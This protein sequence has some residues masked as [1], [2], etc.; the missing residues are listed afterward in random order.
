MSLAGVH[1]V[2]ELAQPLD[3]A[4]HAAGGDL[5]PLGQFLGG[6]YPTRLQQ[7]EQLQDPRRTHVTILIHS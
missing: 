3:V 2:A 7:A 6:P 1:G 5:Q 4:A